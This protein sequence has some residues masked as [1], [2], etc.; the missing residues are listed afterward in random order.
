ME[1]LPRGRQE[2]RP[3]VGGE[4]RRTGTRRHRG[5]QRTDAHRGA[6]TVRVVRRRRRLGDPREHRLE[7][8]AG[9]ALGPRLQVLLRHQRGDLLRRRGREELVD[10]HTLALRE[11]ADLPVQGVR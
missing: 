2:T 5:R 4:E 1:G 8:L 3:E 11:S 10:G 6:S 7:L 9:D